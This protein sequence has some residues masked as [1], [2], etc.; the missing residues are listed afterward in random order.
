MSKLDQL[1]EATL[2]ERDSLPNSLPTPN[3][4]Q[5]I[6]AELFVKCRVDTGDALKAVPVGD[7]ILN[8]LLAISNGKCI[9]DVDL[10]RLLEQSR[11]CLDVM[12]QQ[13][14]GALTKEMLKR[15]HCEGNKRVVKDPGRISLSQITQLGPHEFLH[16]RKRFRKCVLHSAKPACG[17]FVTEVD[18]SC[19]C[20]P[21]IVFHRGVPIPS[22]AV[23]D[24]IPTKPLSGRFDDEVLVITVPRGLADAR[25]RVWSPQSLP[26][27]LAF[28]SAFLGKMVAST[29]SNERLSRSS[30]QKK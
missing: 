24:E 19:C 18:T 13:D 15:C 28:S 27:P 23:V 25:V 2:Q 7:Y 1:R 4:S 22:I 11:L 20:V 8:G 16:R 29:Q 6:D 26:G 5:K 30:N 9:C 21:P 10:L 3:G 12:P 14:F 17:I